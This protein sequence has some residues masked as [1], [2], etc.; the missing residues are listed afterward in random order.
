M[1]ETIVALDVNK[2]LFENDIVVALMSILAI[3]S[4]VLIVRYIFK[5]LNNLK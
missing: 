1:A 3:V 5:E 4:A 2:M